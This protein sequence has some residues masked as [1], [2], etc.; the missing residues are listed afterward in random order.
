MPRIN[1][2]VLPQRTGGKNPATSYLEDL[3][4]RKSAVTMTSCLNRVA[5]MYGFESFLECDWSALRRPHIQSIM[6]K[7]KSEG[8][9]PST[10]NVYL[11]CLK[12][13]AR[14]AW[15]SDLMPQS[16]YL[17]IS[18]MTA[19]RY[20]RL[21]VGRSLSY[22]ECKRLLATCDDGTVVGKRDK[23]ILAMMM[24]C[25]L[26][27]AEVVELNLQN[28]DSRTLSIRLIGKGNKER[29]V[30]LPTDLETI[31]KDWISVR[32]E[33][34]GPMFPRLKPG[35]TE[36]FEERHMNPC[37][38]YRL[39]QG[40]SIKASLRGLTPH[41]LR[42]TFA[43]RM[44]ENGCDLFLLQRAMGHSTVATTARYDRRG[45]RSREKVCRNLKFL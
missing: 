32:G 11:A 23:A 1:A 39:L 25:G 43:T 38:I 31:V 8:L 5:A 28:W 12:G 10:I 27:R 42:R 37:S 34:E 26:R 6:K 17:K 41:D 30:F 20:E 19:I 7:L 35:T 40:R 36:V 16:A 14:E 18:S 2:Y 24:G 45:E 22:R 13:V 21:P 9:A 15:S 29:K 44:L 4:S 3:G 33:T